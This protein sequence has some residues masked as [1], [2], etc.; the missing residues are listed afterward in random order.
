MTWVRSHHWHPVLFSEY[1]QAA[2]PPWRLGGDKIYPERWFSGEYQNYAEFS[3]PCWVTGRI[4][5]A[6]G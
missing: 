3:P 6:V 2:V 1:R 4:L 5:V